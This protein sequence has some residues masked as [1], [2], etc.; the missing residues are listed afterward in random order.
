MEA[1]NSAPIKPKKKGLAG[2]IFGGILAGLV[3]FIL[4]F[5]IIGQL[6]AR[7]NNGIPTYGN[8]QTFRVL[9]DSMEPTYKVDTMIFVKKVDVKTL[10]GPS[11]EGANDGDVIT[12]IR[13]YG[14]SYTIEADIK[15]TITHRIVKVEPQ[16]DGSIYFRTMGDNLNAQTCPASGCS[17]ANADYVRDSDILGKVTGQSMVLGKV[18]GAL[19]NPIVMVVIVVIPLIILFISSLGDLFKE[20]KKEETVT[21]EIPSDDA[22]FHRIKEQEKLK[23]MIELE[24]EKIRKELEEAKGEHKDGQEK[25]SN[26]ES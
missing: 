17:F 21:G 18:S 25:N 24:K 13:N 26:P 16:A 23:I 12:F 4:G 22:E 3:I 1:T 8:Y 2:K 15:L 9:T 6:G 5:Q 19:A 14:P 20:L 7:N 11:A 10:K